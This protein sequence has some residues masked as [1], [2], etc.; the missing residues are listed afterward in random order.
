MLQLISLF[1]FQNLLL[2]ILASFN[3]KVLNSFLL[4]L[5]FSFLLIQSPRVFL[6]STKVPNSLSFFILSFALFG[7]GSVVEHHFHLDLLLLLVSDL[8]VSQVL[9]LLFTEL[10]I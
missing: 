6:L 8:L 3:P 1:P 9:L 2:E 10:D 4:N 7:F 5:L